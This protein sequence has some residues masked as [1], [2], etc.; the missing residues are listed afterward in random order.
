MVIRALNLISNSLKPLLLIFILLVSLKS[1]GQTC[2]SA[3][4]IYHT[5]HDQFVPV[6]FRDLQIDS[7][8]NGLID[9]RYFSNGQ[10]S[11]KYNHDSLGRLT[12]ITS[13]DSIVF[14]YGS[15]SRIISVDYFLWNGISWTYRQDTS[16]VNYFYSANRLDSIVKSTWNGSSMIPFY[17]C[18]RFYN[19]ADTLFQINVERLDSVNSWYIDTLS[20]VSYTPLR[21][22][23]LYANGVIST[24]PDEIRRYDSLERIL[25]ITEIISG[26]ANK[27]QYFSYQCNQ[28]ASYVQT[29]SGSHNAFNTFI[30]FDSLCRIKKIVTGYYQLTGSNTEDVY[31][32]YY[33]SCNTMIVR[34]DEDLRI[35]EGDTAELSAMYFGGT[36][37]YQ[38]DWNSNIVFPNDS[39]SMVYSAPDSSSNFF[40]TVTDSNGL[41][42][43][44]TI[45]VH[46][47]TRPVADIFISAID[48]SSLCQS[49]TLKT[50]SLQGVFY[51][52]S[53]SAS[54]VT[55]SN[56]SGLDIIYNGTYRLVAQENVPYYLTVCPMATDSLVFNYF[57]N[58]AP[59]IDVSLECDVI[60][61]HST[62]NLDY[63]WYKS[64]L[65][66]PDSINDTLSVNQIGAYYAIGVDSA[67]CLSAQSQTI[68]YQSVTVPLSL[69]VNIG[70]PTCDTCSDGNV[71]VQG[72]GGA[73]SG[74]TY[75]IN[76]VLM[77][78]SFQDSLPAGLYEFCVTDRNNCVFC[79]SSVYISISELETKKVFFYP[80]P[81]KNILY[82]SFP[83]YQQSSKTEF[84]LLDASGRT[85]RKYTLKGPDFTLSRESLS[86]GIYIF[87]ILEDG[88][89]RDRGKIVV[90]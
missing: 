81:F 45:A 26:W 18:I 64:N 16:N 30:T 2:D 12:S 82:L 71:N 13:T 25:N 87:S 84:M 10:Q 33:T 88:I 54:P 73:S 83:Y 43:T 61:A 79:L 9:T 69:I 70:H 5:N 78:G 15:L 38:L 59:Q 37:P 90:N 41:M 51:S 6:T 85:V 65:L 31:E 72:V 17:R 36:P 44:D 86:A 66:I 62:E 60:V 11:I 58:P 28:L 89:V 52:W 7:L 67:G 49:A 55:I 29:Y 57:S 35:C 19:I 23:S 47:S 76:G 75:T 39:S 8:V 24:Y 77:A 53:E 40:V 21:V 32:Y 20:T 3:I 68:I 46:V 14:T 50:D 1:S 56:F 63:Q 22:D 80:N 34:A 27:L 42:V 74:Y 48:T 4:V